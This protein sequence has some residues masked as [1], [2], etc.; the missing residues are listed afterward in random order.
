MEAPEVEETGSLP[1]MITKDQLIVYIDHAIRNGDDAKLKDLL[2]NMHYADLADY[3]S[4]A[5]FE[6]ISKITSI[7]KDK[8]NPELFLELEVD[9]L[10][11]MRQ[12]YGDPTFVKILDKLSIEDLLSLLD[13]LDDK[14]K[15]EIIELFSR[16][17]KE[18]I[19]RGLSYPKNSAG[20]LMQTKFMSLSEDKT[21]EEALSYL[22]GNAML[23]ENCDEIFVTNKKNRVVGTLHVSKIIR[24]SRHE[25][26]K[27]IM[28]TN[29]H[30]IDAFLDQEEVSYM[31]RHYGLTA[32]PVVN[33]QKKIVG[34]IYTDQILGVVEEEVEE[35]I[36]KMGGIGMTDLYSTLLKT[37][38]QRFPWLF[39]NLITACITSLAI[40][41][42]G[43]QVEQKVILAAVMT[44]V[45]SMGGNAGTQSVTIAV[46]AIANKDIATSNIG[47]VILKEISVCALSGAILGTLGGC[48]LYFFY[49]DPSVSMV[50]ALAVTINSLLAGLWGS[51]IPISISKAG[52]DPA[53]S[54]GVI[55][56]F[57]TDILGFLIFLG[58]ASVLIL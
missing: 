9:V 34:V 11:T 4:F 1:A 28:N 16:D 23:P 10:K 3:L 41:F 31:F 43:S 42:F 7:L 51:L 20:V 38:S 2:Q 12:I 29:I 30:L 55:L 40:K 50:F 54:S 15:A 53:V 33:K 13:D 5:N 44:I 57:L 14:T 56:T 52:M 8:I 32:A 26:L 58:L 27:N 47:Q 17:K 49:K 24:A 48:I 18:L 19:L 46:R 45:A 6:A 39:V 36:L 21:V 35:D 22:S 25:E 37:V